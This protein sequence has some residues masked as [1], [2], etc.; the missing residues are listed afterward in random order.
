MNS[1]GSIK[2]MDLTVDLSYFVVVVAVVVTMCN[3]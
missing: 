2:I 3:C 1:S